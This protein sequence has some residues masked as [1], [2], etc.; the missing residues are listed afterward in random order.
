MIFACAEPACSYTATTKKALRIH[1]AR[2]ATTK[3]YACA[4]GFTCKHPSSL[5][6]HKLSHGAIE[7]AKPLS[8]GGH[9][10]QARVA[11]LLHLCKLGGC[12]YAA[13]SIH[14]LRRHRLLLHSAETGSLACRCCGYLATSYDDILFHARQH[15]GMKSYA[16]RRSKA[17]EAPGVI[18]VEAAKEKL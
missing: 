13:P 17:S 7:V 15:G 12:T 1:G 11:A 2:H 8:E 6:R 3:A 4:C 18:G 10:V 9:R 16:A 14:H 5:S